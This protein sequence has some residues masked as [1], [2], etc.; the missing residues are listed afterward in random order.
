[1]CPQWGTGSTFLSTTQECIIFSLTVTN[2]SLLSNDVHQ[3]DLTAACLLAFL[4][5][6]QPSPRISQSHTIDKYVFRSSLNSLPHK[7]LCS[8]CEAVII[9]THSRAL[10]HFFPLGSKLFSPLII[11]LLYPWFLILFMA[12]WLF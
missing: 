1:M 12:R 8:S 7:L 9:S 3:Q 10:E 5:S 2:G 11:S 6:S 4:P